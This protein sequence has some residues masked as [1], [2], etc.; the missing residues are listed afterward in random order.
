MTGFKRFFPDEDERE[1][2]LAV[3]NR[4]SPQPLKNLLEKML[5]RQSV[6][7]AEI[8]DVDETQ[9]MVYLVEDG[10]VI[11][12]SPLIE[13]ANAILLVNSDLYI[14]GARELDEIHVPAVIDGLTDVPFRLR[15][16]PESNKEKLLLITISRYIERLALEHDGGKH[17]ASFQHLSRIE[18]ERGTRTVYDCLATTDTDV[19]VYGIPD[20]TPPPHFDVT[21]HGAWTKPFR[22]V[23]FVTHVP[24]NEQDRHAALVAIQT[25]PRTWEAFWTYDEDR[26]TAINRHI[27]RNL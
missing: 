11:A 15:G 1:L 6:T 21:I 27:E 13:V 10:D 18:D 25:D 7:I 14:T 20:W 4:N 24:A 2:S 22:D 5:D 23:W 9:D 16:Y 8:S 19:H 17:R 3:V 26:V 12:R